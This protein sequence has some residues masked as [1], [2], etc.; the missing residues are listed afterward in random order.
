MISPFFS[1]FHYCFLVE[2]TPS[3]ILSFLCH[4][5]VSQKSPLF[6]FYY[7]VHLYF[8]SQLRVICSLINKVVVVCT[9]LIYFFVVIYVSIN[10][11]FL[12]LCHFYPLMIFQ[13]FSRLPVKPLFK[14]YRSF[15]HRPVSCT[16]APPCCV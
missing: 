13:L 15:P 11:Y 8:L 7:I 10:F 1:Q 2:L 9:S 5:T 3:S 16:T 4:I 6:P 14:L 12:L